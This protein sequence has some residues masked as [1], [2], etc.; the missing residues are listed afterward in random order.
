MSNNSMP[1][2]LKKLRENRGWTKTQVAEKLGKSLATYANYEYGI[3]D[4]DTNTLIK[5]ADLYDISIDYLVGRTENPV[6]ASQMD[7][8]FYK[9]ILDPDL[10]RFVIQELPQSPVED[11]EKLRVIWRII[12]DEDKKS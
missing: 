12:K 7:K 6:Q 8:E 4:P 9:A 10:K 2:I 11:L 5:I 1:K 3:R